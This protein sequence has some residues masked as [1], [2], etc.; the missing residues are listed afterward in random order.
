LKLPENQVLRQSNHFRVINEIDP[1][2]QIQDLHIDFVLKFIMF[3]AVRQGQGS[4]FNWEF[5]GLNNFIAYSP[6]QDS[7]DDLRL[8][9]RIDWNSEIYYLTSITINGYKIISADSLEISHVL[10]SNMRPM[11]V[12]H[13]ERFGTTPS[14]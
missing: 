9:F 8:D 4:R 2:D 11:W 13:K 6:I 10:Y 1:L 3:E 7:S 5:H 12:K 14:K